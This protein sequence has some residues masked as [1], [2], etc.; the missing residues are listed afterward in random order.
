MI[1]TTFWTF[2]MVL[3]K[4]RSILEN[5]PNRLHPHTYAHKASK[6]PTEGQARRKVIRYKVLS[7]T[8]SSAPGLLQGHG[9]IYCL[10]DWWAWEAGG[11]W[12]RPHWAGVREITAFSWEQH[13]CPMRRLAKQRPATCSVGA[14]NCQKDIWS[15]QMQGESEYSQSMMWTHAVNNGNTWRLVV[16]IQKLPTLC[17]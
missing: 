9:L 8:C 3:R 11:Y 10:P 16:C 17:N 7:V 13:L 1:K 4:K 14:M 5:I 6:S 2:C 15:H 12:P